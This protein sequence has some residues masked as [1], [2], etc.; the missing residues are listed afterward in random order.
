METTHTIN[1]PDD[2]NDFIFGGK[3]VFTLRSIKTG[4]RFTYKVTASKDGKVF[5]VS[6]LTGSNNE[7]DYSYMGIIPGDCQA[8]GKA[9]LRAT[10]KSRI[11][12]AAPSFRALQWA[13]GNLGSPAM[14]FFHEGRCC[15]CAR[16]L[17]DPESI[18]IGMGPEC[19]QRRAA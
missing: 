9:N 4:V 18:T 8:M 3:A 17:T 16:R 11:T 13:L 1:A 14:E 7:T 6:V 12:P 15:R 2:Q 19:R 10:A 5:F